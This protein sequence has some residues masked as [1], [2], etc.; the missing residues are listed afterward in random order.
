MD[1]SI[2]A[3]SAS[4][5]RSPYKPLLSSAVSSMGCV[6]KLISR[7]VEGSVDHIQLLLAREAHEV[8]RIARYPDRQRRI[9]F[10]MLHGVF[11][12]LAVQNVD[13]HVVTRR[14]EE[15]VE[16]RGE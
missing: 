14:A 11:E 10:G 6:A 8:H 3:N 12:C 1:R 16:H 5:S 4:D 9:V 2:F 7:S 13:V 15:R